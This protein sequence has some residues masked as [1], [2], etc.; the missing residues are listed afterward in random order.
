M[1]QTAGSGGRPNGDADRSARSA[2]RSVRLA[3]ELAWAVAPL[4]CRVSVLLVTISGVTPA[5]TA[6]LQR[7][8]LNELAGT[9]LGGYRSA[10]GRPGVS[11]SHVIVLAMILAAVGLVTATV[12]Y[13]QRYVGAELRRGSGCW[14]RTGCTG[15]STRSRD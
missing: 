9:G 7:A 1:P 4:V 14:R 15:R 6:W 3:A 13:A 2:V 12:S 10:A 8:I 11:A 5:V